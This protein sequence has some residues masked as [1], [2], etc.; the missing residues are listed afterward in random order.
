MPVIN[1]F[2]HLKY[3][4]FQGCF[5][6]KGNSTGLAV[7]KKQFKCFTI[8]GLRRRFFLSYTISRL[9]SIPVQSFLRNRERSY[10]KEV[11]YAI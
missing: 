1:I 7:S 5:I 6:C 2:S 11:S 9:F 10:P 4:F 8:N 3:L